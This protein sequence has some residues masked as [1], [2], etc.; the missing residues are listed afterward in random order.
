MKIKIRGLEIN[1]CHGVHGFEKQTPQRFVIDADL[2]VDFYEAAKHDDLNKTVNYSAVCSLIAKT[3]TENCLNLIES[4]AY[5]CAFAVMENFATVSKITLTVK[6][7][8]APLKVKF[9]S[10][11]AEAELERNTVYLSLGSSMGDRAA[12]LNSAVDK[13]KAVRGVKVEKVSEY[14]TTEPYGGVAKNSFLNC[15]AKI[16]T[17]ISPEQLLLEIHR[18]EKECR[19]VRD[20]RWDDRTLDIDIIFFDNKTVREENLIIPHPDYANRPF[21]T[22]P[23]KNVEPELFLHDRNI[24][25]K[26]L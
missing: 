3:V 21:V 15:A 11:E 26:D 18:I 6:K 1:A 4:L 13:L 24:Y 8:D 14:M 5:A 9:D 7:P 10:V 23:L 16:K 22:E 25:L 17:L 12:Y 2:S 20:K 19:R